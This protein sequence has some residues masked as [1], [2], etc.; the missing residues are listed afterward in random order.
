MAA[1]TGWLV[2]TPEARLARVLSASHAKTSRPLSSCAAFRR[3][4]APSIRPVAL[5]PAGTIDLDSS[6]RYRVLL[7]ESWQSF[8]VTD[9]LPAV[10]TPTASARC[11]ASVGGIRGKFR[12][13]RLP[14]R[15]RSRLSMPQPACSAS[16]HWRYVL[17]WC[18]RNTAWW[19]VTWANPLACATM[20][21]YKGEHGGCPRRSHCTPAGL[22]WSWWSSRSSQALDWLTTMQNA[23]RRPSA[24]C[25]RTCSASAASARSSRR[26]DGT[27]T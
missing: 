14:G 1:L 22:P 26:P 12:P 17:T 21:S 11:N 5:R 18:G 4:I 3:Q 7:R 13:F 25:I 2:R 24:V 9:L 20:N 23:Y 10:A 27:A 15:E 6:L 8:L 16:V 19:Q